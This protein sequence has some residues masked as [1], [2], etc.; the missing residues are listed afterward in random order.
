MQDRR[1]FTVLL[2]ATILLRPSSAAAND[3]G[4]CSFEPR[5]VSFSVDGPS[6]VVTW[7]GNAERIT[8]G[9]VELPLGEWTEREDL[10]RSCYPDDQR[11]WKYRWDDDDAWDDDDSGAG[12]DDSGL[13]DDDAG[14]PGTMREWCLE[15]PRDCRD[16][17]N[18][19]VRE[20]YGYCTSVVRTRWTEECVPSRADGGWTHTYVL[21]GQCDSFEREL[22]V[23]RV[24][25]CQPDLDDGTPLPPVEPDDGDE[26][27][28]DG[29]AG[30]SAGWRPSTSPL[31]LALAL[32]GVGAGILFIDRRR[33]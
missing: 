6:V 26:G 5:S 9:G 10:G 20:C 30:C 7:L 2:V 14:Q 24:N 3:P 18:D 28:C 15:Y 16:C 21:E 33:P 13:G 11:P 31:P 8:R 19:G 17:N 25:D 12:D 22:H 29:P 1:I 23:D 4:P 32:L 27:G